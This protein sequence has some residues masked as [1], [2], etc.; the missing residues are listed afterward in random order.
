[1]S[2]NKLAKF[3]EMKSFENV[4]QA[5]F[6]LIGKEKFYLR[7][8][9]AANFFGNSNPVIL[10][11]GCGKGEYSVALAEKNPDKNY[12]GIDIKGAR[13]WAGAKVH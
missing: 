7:G 13:L 5:P 8:T 2:R 9:W 3:E 12:I 1:M 4:V 11:I 10:E 6:H